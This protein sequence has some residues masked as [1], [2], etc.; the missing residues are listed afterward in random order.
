MGKPDPVIYDVALDM[1][2]VPKEC[3]L[4]IG[5]SLQHDIQGTAHETTASAISR[6]NCLKRLAKGIK[7][8]SYYTMFYSWQVFN[9]SK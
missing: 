4:A 8:S 1:W 7:D 9:P 2:D 3:V 6:P 5:D